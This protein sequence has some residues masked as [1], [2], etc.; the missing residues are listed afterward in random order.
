ME[1]AAEPGAE[2]DVRGSGVNR[3]EA[4]PD[5]GRSESV[6]ERADRNWIEI[7]QELRVAQTGTQI[8]GGFLLAIAFQPRFRDLDD[9][10]LTLYLVLVGIAGLAAALGM[11]PVSLHRAKFGR[12]KKPEI[13]RLGNRLLVAD[14]VVVAALAV[15]VTSL[16]FDYA[17]SR[18]AGVAVIGVGAAVVALLWWVVPRIA[19]RSDDDPEP[20]SDDRLRDGRN[21][22]HQSGGS[23]EM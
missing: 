2:D 6:N 19:I 13:V 10:Q 18:T 1:P 14:L 9:Y 17:V 8:M 12:R 5:D 4:L 15:G 3:W 20:G 16:I 22:G 11:A 23:I 21:P 7:L